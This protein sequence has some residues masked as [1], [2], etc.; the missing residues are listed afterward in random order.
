MNQSITVFTN[1]KAAVDNLIA[2]QNSSFESLF[3]QTLGLSEPFPYADFIANSKAL[4]NRQHLMVLSPLAFEVGHNQVQLQATPQTLALTLDE[5]RKLGEMLAPLLVESGIEIIDYHSEYLLLSSKQQ[6]NAKPWFALVSEPMSACLPSGANKDF[7][8]RL[9][10]ECQML[11]NQAPLNIERQQQAKPMINMLWL[12]G[13]GHWQFLE[14]PLY[15]FSDD[16]YL[17]AK[18]RQMNAIK[19]IDKNTLLNLRAKDIGMPLVLFLNK[20]ESVIEQ[21]LQQINRRHQITRVWCDGYLTQ[22]KKPW[23]HRYI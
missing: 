3:F 9:L 18:V 5:M 13:M 10:A 11:L 1:T 6:V 14:K 16:A 12:W 4:N 7:A 19:V 17:L 2:W 21:K 20:T 22:N 23:W 8:N 15:F